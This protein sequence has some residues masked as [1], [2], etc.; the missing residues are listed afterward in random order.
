MNFTE[1]DSTQIERLMVLLEKIVEY[2]KNDG[3]D[4]SSYFY[5]EKAINILKNRDIMGMKK[6]YGHVMSDL[7]MMVDRGQYGDGLDDVSNEIVNILNSNG[8]FRGT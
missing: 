2:L 4:K 6:V 1:K 5:I 3:C 7:R 8:I